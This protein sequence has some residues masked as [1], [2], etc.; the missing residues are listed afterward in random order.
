MNEVKNEIP[1]ITNLGRT[2]ILTTVENKISD[3]SDFVKIADYDAKVSEM[4][5]TVLLLLIIINSQIIYLMQR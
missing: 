5:K 2:S 4:E 1:Y 3:F